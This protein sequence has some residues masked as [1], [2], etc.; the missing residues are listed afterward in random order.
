MT[1]G[2][3]TTTACPIPDL[4]PES[5]ARWRASEVGAIT[6]SLQHALMLRLIG[7]VA[8]KRVLDVGCGDGKLAVE[9]A[10]RGGGQVAAVDVSPAMIEAARERAK[11]LA[12]E[13]DLQAASV[14]SLPF[15]D[16]SFDIVVAFT[17][18]C[19]VQDAAP[20][21]AEISRVLKPGGRLVIGELNRWSTWAAQRRAR[22]WLGS[23]M[24]RQGH[25]RTPHELRDLARAAGLV[26][27]NITG[28]T[29]YPRSAFVARLVRRFDAP[30]GRLTTF[31]AAFI[32]LSATKP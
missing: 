25:F 16:A 26:P 17:I 11:S 30:L 29:Y 27:G 19:F 23:A 15:P 8:N 12:V 31:G 22:A 28:A 2:N 18:L 5:Y 21:F 32:A 20:A 9:L 13:L 10:Q 1:V 14:Q 3:K 6:E 4:G 24:W 7:D